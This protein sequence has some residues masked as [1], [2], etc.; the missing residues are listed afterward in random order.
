MRSPSITESELIADPQLLRTEM[1]SGPV[2]AYSAVVSLVHCSVYG[3]GIAACGACTVHIDGRPLRC[4][5]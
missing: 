5:T 1:V 4:A 3:C 2:R